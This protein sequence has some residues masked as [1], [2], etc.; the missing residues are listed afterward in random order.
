[1]VRLMSRL[2]RRLKRRLK[3]MELKK[4]KILKRS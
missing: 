4:R 1:M 2:M 3:R